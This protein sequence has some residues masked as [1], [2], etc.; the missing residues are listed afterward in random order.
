MQTAMAGT[1]FREAATAVNAMAQV[2]KKLDNLI[3]QF[4]MQKKD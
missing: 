4:F 2:F 3:P 1:A